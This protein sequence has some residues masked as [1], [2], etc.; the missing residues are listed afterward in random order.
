MIN[1]PYR[2]H[3]NSYWIHP[4]KLI[5]GGYP[6]SMSVYDEVGVERIQAIL[7]A[8]INVFVDLTEKDEIR[9]YSQLVR[10]EAAK[11]A[12]IAHYYRFSIQDANAPTPQI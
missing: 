9:D 5:A 1:E 4:G 7:K 2:P 11:L 12:K 10:E 3:N 8:G 6:L